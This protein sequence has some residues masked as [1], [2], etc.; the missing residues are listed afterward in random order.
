MSLG[1]IA[2][3]KGSFVSVKGTNSRYSTD[4][5]T[6]TQRGQLARALE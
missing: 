1:G 3:G 4:G 5:V 2:Y 6:W